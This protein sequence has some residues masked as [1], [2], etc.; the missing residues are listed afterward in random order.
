MSIVG[1]L[2]LAGFAL[3]VLLARQ[4][5]VADELATLWMVSG[6]SFG[7][8]VAAVHTD[9]EITP[10]LSFAASWLTSRIAETPELLRAPSV[11]AGTATI[12]LVYAVGVRTVGRRAGQLAAALTALSPFM[13]HYSSEAR[14][15]ALMML[16][17]LSSTL[18]L[19]IAVEDGRARWWTAYA[20]ASL[21]AALSHYT[22]V[23]VLAAQLGWVLWAHPAA[24]RPALLANAAGAAGFLPWLPGLTA[25][26]RSTTTEI[27]SA[28]QPFT[29]EWVRTSLAH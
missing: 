14:G 22:C 28:L 17:A 18:A 13:L 15:Y 24:R 5:L 27:L 11:L 29:F 8:M 26:L 12:P 20:A 23:F 6:R 7:D 25:D 10:P 4:S 19:L 9:A 16:F 3:R 21:A 1:A 2:T